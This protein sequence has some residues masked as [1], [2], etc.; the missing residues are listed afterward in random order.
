MTAAKPVAVGGGPVE[1]LLPGATCQFPTKIEE[2]VRIKAGCVVDVR[3]NALVAN[4]RTLTIEPGV[5]LRFHEKSYLEVGHKGS[6]IIAR[7]TKERP[8]I[9]T[10]AAM[11]PKRADWVGIVRA[12][13][14]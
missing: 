7:G 3:A 2:D 6:R 10:S 12:L 1:P 11:S 4:G 13:Q 5:T 9:F 14:K 8:I